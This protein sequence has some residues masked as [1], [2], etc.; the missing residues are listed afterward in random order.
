MT[1]TRT[2]KATAAALALTMGL[3][4]AAMLPAAPAQAGGSLS[5]SILPGSPEAEQA[6]RLGLG[7]YALTQGA[8][9]GHINQTGTGNSAG[10]AQNGGGNVGIVHQDG[11]GHNGT[12]TQNGNGNAYGLF[13][14]G[15]NTNGHVNQ[16]GN[17]RAGMTFQLGW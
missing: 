14:F 15:R 1:A 8:R 5:I 17:G 12:V 16:T 10:V 2:L 6:M 9:N 3:T 7:I 11:H 13:Q 4:T